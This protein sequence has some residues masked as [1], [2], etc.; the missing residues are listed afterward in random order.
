MKK[1]SYSFHHW[2]VE[3]SPGPIRAVPSPSPQPSPSGRG[4]ILASQ[5][6]NRISLKHSSIARA[7]SL[8]Q[9]ERVGVRG[10]TTPLQ[11]AS[12]TTPEIVELHEPSGQAQGL[13]KGP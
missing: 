3:R 9:G 5:W 11:R 1:D 12:R 13:F 6:T 10:N 2:R 7:H 4:R 8:S